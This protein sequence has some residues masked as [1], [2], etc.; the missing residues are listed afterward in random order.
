ML[1]EKPVV[2]RFFCAAKLGGPLTSHYSPSDDAV[3]D[4]WLVVLFRMVINLR[5]ERVLRHAATVISNC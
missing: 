2:A 3:E 4:F 5:N 1:L